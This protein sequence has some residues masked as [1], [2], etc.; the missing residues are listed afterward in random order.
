MECKHQNKYIQK[1]IFYLI[2]ERIKI[3]FQLINSKISNSHKIVNLKNLYQLYLKKA[4]SKFKKIC[5][6]FILIIK[7]IQNDKIINF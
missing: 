6:K 5:L 7:I 4:D 3:S 2:L 1:K